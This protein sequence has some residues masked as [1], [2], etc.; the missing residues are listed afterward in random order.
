MKICRTGFGVRSRTFR[1]QNG[2]CQRLNPGGRVQTFPSGISFLA[3]QHPNVKSGVSGTGPEIPGGK[4]L[5]NLVGKK[6]AGNR[7]NAGQYE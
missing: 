3:Q 2:M 4:T 6:I 5:P 1:F 7:K